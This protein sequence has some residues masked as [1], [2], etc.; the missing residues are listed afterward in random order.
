MFEY[1]YWHPSVTADVVLIQRDKEDFSDPK[2]LMVRRK[3]E[4]YKWKWA[5]PG[6]FLESNDVTMESCAVRELYEET[7]IKVDEESLDLACVLSHKDRDPRER[8]ISTVYYH[9]V[10]DDI[11]NVQPTAKDDAISAQWISLFDL[12]TND[13]AFD[14]IKAITN[15][16]KKLADFYRA[17]TTKQ[18]C[19]CALCGYYMKQWMLYLELYDKFR[20]DVNYIE[21][22]ED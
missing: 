15:A 8:V 14:H 18:T 6:G 13:L 20:F 3:N 5:L 21:N 9:E 19:H 7:N 11:N 1:E 22:Y 2:I 16:M 4:P 12:P 10:I 17:L